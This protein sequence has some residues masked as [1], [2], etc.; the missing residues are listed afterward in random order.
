MIKC[1]NMMTKSRTLVAIIINNCR[2]IITIKI[3][4]LKVLEDYIGR[5]VEIFVDC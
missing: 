2:L 4:K 1:V 5:L 3:T